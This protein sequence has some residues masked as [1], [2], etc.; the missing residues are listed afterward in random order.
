MHSFAL[1]Y[2]IS[3]FF[4]PK[5]YRQFISEYSKSL[6][7][8]LIIFICPLIFFSHYL[9]RIFFMF[10]TGLMAVKFVHYR[11]EQFTSVYAH[12]T[13]TDLD[14]LAS[15]TEQRQ[16]KVTAALDKAKRDGLVK[17]YTR[18]TSKLS[19]AAAAD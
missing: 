2:R 9:T 14:I 10:C 12:K 16:R 8:A 4:L 15:V 19:T 3:Q 7:V 13:A 5:M 6:I 17:R 11:W 1:L 18:Q